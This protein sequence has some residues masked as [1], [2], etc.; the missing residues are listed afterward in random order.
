MSKFTAFVAAGL[1]LGATPAF[2]QSITVDTPDVLKGRLEVE[3]DNTYLR[4]VSNDDD[5]FAHQMVV[6][7]APV[8][9]VRLGLGAIANDVVG[10]GPRVDAYLAEIR[11]EGPRPSW[12]PFEWGLVGTYIGGGPDGVNDSIAL[13]AIA[14]REVGPVEI[15]SNLDIVTQ[16]GGGASEDVHFDLLLEGRL[17]ITE[18]FILALT[19]AGALG[20]DEEFGDL[21]SLGQYI[22]P[23]A[24]VSLPVPV[25]NSALGIEA[26]ALFGLNQESL[27]ALG[28]VNLTWATQ[29]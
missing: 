20:T 17:P 28:K 3:L 4:E 16:V 19:Y 21:G 9:N 1:A 7:Y 5:A 13:R 27:D 6:A 29:F 14:A 23:T 10:Q 2:A 22:G 26:G 11:F 8:E 15:I 12:M 25:A 18:Q 24:Y